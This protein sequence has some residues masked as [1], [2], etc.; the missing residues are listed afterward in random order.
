[1]F[2]F[3][4]EWTYKIPSNHPVFKLFIS[5]TRLFINGSFPALGFSQ[6][7]KNCNMAGHEMC[8]WI[9]PQRYKRSISCR[10]IS[11]ISTHTV[12]GI[13]AHGEIKFTKSTL[14]H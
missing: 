10:L 1:M 14:P 7:P 8:V 13:A 5:L 3:A 4:P 6:S 9:V 12:Y 11:L 2:L